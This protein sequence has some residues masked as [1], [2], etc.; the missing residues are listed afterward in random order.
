MNYIKTLQSE[1]ADLAIEIA[2]YVSML[3]QL[4]AYLCS[5]KFH[6]DP[7]VQCADVLRRI[8][9]T[10]LDSARDWIVTTTARAAYGKD[11]E[12]QS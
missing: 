6:D 12:P 11:A 5:Q 4:R 8:D 3:A 2:A 7:T 9:S 1:N 10:A